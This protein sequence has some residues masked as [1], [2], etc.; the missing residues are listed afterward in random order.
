[1]S[2]ESFQIFRLE[3]DAGVTCLRVSNRYHPALLDSGSLLINYNNYDDFQKSNHVK[4]FGKHIAVV[5]AHKNDAQLLG[6][7]GYLSQG[8]KITEDGN[9]LY[10]VRD[11]PSSPVAFLRADLLSVM[12]KDVDMKASYEERLFGLRTAVPAVIEM[13]VSCEQG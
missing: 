12:L 13:K 11:A 2:V 3:H 5:V 4:G 6:A 10:V 7:I 9:I 8:A 1:M